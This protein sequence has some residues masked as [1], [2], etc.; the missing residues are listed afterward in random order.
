[1]DLLVVV[2]HNG[3]IDATIVN[4][5]HKNGVKVIAYDRIINDCGLDLYVSFDNEKVGELQAQYILDNAPIGNYILIGGSPT[6]FNAKL[7]RDGQLK[8]LQPSID[9]GKIKIVSDQWT[10]DWQ[11]IEALKHTENALTKNNNDIV[12]IVASND[13]TAGGAIQALEEQKLAGKVF[14]S[15]QDAD[16]AACQRIVA[17][18]QTMTVYKPIKLLAETAAKAAMAMIQNK[19]IV[20]ANQKVNNGK[21]DVPS[22]LLTPISVDQFN[23]AETV[24]KDGYQKAD[25]VYKDEGK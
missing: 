20:N 16:L 11:P 17:G 2:P 7:I 3:K 12:A 24:I 5:A 13:G 4:E 25:D 23:L 8:I 15:G 10:V 1:V 9:S 18:T 21:I 22:I 6:D 19:P 14:V